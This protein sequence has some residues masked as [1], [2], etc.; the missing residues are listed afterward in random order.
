M[1]ASTVQ[2]STTHRPP[3]GTAPAE[4]HPAR[5]RAAT[6]LDG[7]YEDPNGPDPRAHDPHP[8]TSGP[9]PLPQDP[10]ACLRPPPTP[11]PAPPSLTSGPY[12]EPAAAG[13]RTGQRS[14]L[15]HRLE[16]P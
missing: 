11:D 1:L 4:P 5:P 15:E 14:T 10:T 2:F 13:G 16:H 12:W 6:E 9:G 8:D 7:W 3:P